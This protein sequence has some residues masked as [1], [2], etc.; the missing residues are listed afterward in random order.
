MPERAPRA[1]CAT[2][3]RALAGAVDRRARA[4]QHARVAAGRRRTSAGAAE[5]LAAAEDL[6]PRRAG[7][8][9]EQR[10][11]AASPR[12]PSA[13]CAV[14]HA[15][16]HASAPGIG[17]P[18]RSGG[19]RRAPRPAPCRAG[20][21]RRRRRQALRGGSSGPVL[22]SRYRLGRILVPER[23]GED[24]RFCRRRR[25]GGAMSSASERREELKAVFQQ[26]SGLHELPAAR[27]HAHDRRVRLRQRRRRPD[28]RRR[29]P[30][31]ERGQAGPAVRRPGRPAAGHAARRDRPDP[32]RRVRRATS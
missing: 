2:V 7:A 18:R 17:S 28:V 15:Q 6:E 19:R 13:I 8:V 5:A 3:Q 25:Y 23:C 20:P 4:A 32:R 22:A 1:P 30:G 12:R 31:R 21:R 29:G 11:G 16:Q 27:G 24:G 26:A 10:P 9:A 14:G